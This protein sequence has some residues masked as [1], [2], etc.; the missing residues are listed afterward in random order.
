M[1]EVLVEGLH[2]LVYNHTRAL[3]L[4]AFHIRG[5][6]EVYN[7]SHL[8]V[9]VHVEDGKVCVEDHH[10]Y[11]TDEVCELASGISDQVYGEALGQQDHIHYPVAHNR[12]PLH[13]TVEAFEL[14]SD[15]CDQVDEEVLR[16]AHGQ[17]SLRGVCNCYC[18]HGQVWEK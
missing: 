7:H 15:T 1:E 5:L 12:S 13:R 8:R 6:V 9:E 4:G 11:W 16:T 10:M 14:A 2:S 17:H 3:A 18:G